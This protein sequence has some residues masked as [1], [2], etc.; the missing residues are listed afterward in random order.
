MK[1]INLAVLADTCNKRLLALKANVSLKAEI[2]IEGETHKVSDIIQ[3]YQECLDTRASVEKK[4]ADVKAAL[5]VSANAEAA[6]RAIEPSLKAWVAAKF[7]SNSNVAHEFGYTPRKA[8]S[9]TVENKFDALKLAGATRTARHT[10][11]SKQKKKVKGSVADPIAAPAA[12]AP[13]V[14]PAPTAAPTSAS[15][16][17]LNG[18][19][20]PRL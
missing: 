15:N 8:A 2:G 16:G 7:G 9:R 5:V 20:P 18:G 11:G 4:R 3:I 12:P 10:M 1:R 6:R 14:A 19:A 13:S 17:V